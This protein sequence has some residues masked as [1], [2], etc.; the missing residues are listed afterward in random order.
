MP[1]KEKTNA[2]K[3]LSV[4][5]LV[6]GLTFQPD[7]VFQL[8]HAVPRLRGTAGQSGYSYLQLEVSSL[9][10]G[11]R[12]LGSVRP[13]SA[14][15]R[16]NGISKLELTQLIRSTLCVRSG[17]QA[18]ERHCN[19]LDLPHCF[20]QVN[21]SSGMIGE[22]PDLKH[23]CVSVLGVEWVSW[24]NSTFSFRFHTHLARLFF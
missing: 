20:R 23:E 18:R 13:R 11:G 7:L 21:Q 8:F 3:F 16:A 15:P 24:V 4:L 6:L 10:E 19:Q 12:C 5:L 17:K 9:T 22:L 14:P 2:N 1:Q